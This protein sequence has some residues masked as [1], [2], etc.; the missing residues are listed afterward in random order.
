MTHLVVRR[1]PKFHFKPGD[2]VY[3]NIPIV[4]KYEWHP[5]SI[6]SAPENSEFIWLHI[7]SCGNWT[8]RLYQFASSAR[9]DACNNTSLQLS[10]A[11]GSV[12]GRGS[13]FAPTLNI[14]TNTSGSNTVVAASS[15]RHSM[16]TRMSVILLSESH[17][18]MI[19][20][21]A[22]LSKQLSTIGDEKEEE[23]AVCEEESRSQSQST[24]KK[25]VS[26]G[27]DTLMQEEE[28][29]SKTVIAVVP[30]KTE[31]TMKKSVSYEPN[32]VVVV[33]PTRH[34]GILKVMMM[35][36]NAKM[37]SKTTSLTVNGPESL[38][39]SME[40]QVVGGNV[41]TMPQKEEVE[42][43]PSESTPKGSMIRKTVILTESNNLLNT[44]VEKEE[45]N[46]N[47]AHAAV[48]KQLKFDL[49]QLPLDRNTPRQQ[50]LDQDKSTVFEHAPCYKKNRSKS[51]DVLIE[52]NNGVK[53]SCLDK[54]SEHFKSLDIQAHLSQEANKFDKMNL[55][56]EYFSRKGNFFSTLLL[57]K[58]KFGLK[59]SEKDRKEVKE[60][61]PASPDLKKQ[62]VVLNMNDEKDNNVS[63]ATTG[64]SSNHD[65]NILGY[66][67]LYR[68]HNR[69]SANTIGLDEQWRLKVFLDGPYGTPSQSIFDA[70]HA[71][72]VAAGIGITPFASILQSLMNRYRRARASCPNCDY[73]IGQDPEFS[74]GEQALS[75]RKVDFIWITREQR[76]LEWFISMLS[77]MEIE[78]AK[79]L[80]IHQ[81]HHHQ[82]TTSSSK[83]PLF[84]ETHLYVTS[85]KRQSD[86]RSISLHL[87][88]DAICSQEDSHLID[89]LKKR[90]H[91]GRPNWD[92]VLQSLIR[93]QKGKINMFYCGPPNLSGVL[94]KKCNEYNIVFK[95]EIF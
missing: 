24:I 10:G 60:E 55:A 76:S 13:I 83:N 89:G 73:R 8:K 1:P 90:T 5:F 6:S 37:D 35:Q 48:I 31:T 74:T 92:I 53:E 61:T 72:L 25:V 71:V 86:L 36:D 9:F 12:F 88:L 85:A 41:E 7:K 14:P 11:R 64:N 47:Q 87:T 91:F 66:M 78:Q 15:A 54:L 38:D 79:Q 81:K 77:Q 33:P 3:V 43:T 39:R 58:Y 84:L 51:I 82:S 44:A 20:K 4:A 21:S 70:E 45:A 93:K 57:L 95:K 68:K 52:T 32:S 67:K 40:S 75:V 30:T 56:D 46:E 27:T 26:F 29:K 18:H 23:D 22:I 59:E 34:K 19:S 42:K 17:Q 50:S 94:Q 2:Y 80:Q 62:V 49:E 28:A 65:D 63:A 16:R 69:V